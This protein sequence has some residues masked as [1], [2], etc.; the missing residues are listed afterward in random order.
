MQPTKEEYKTMDFEV[1]SK[2]KIRRT[3]LTAKED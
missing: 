2:I 1:E 3:G